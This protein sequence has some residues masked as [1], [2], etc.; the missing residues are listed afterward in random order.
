MQWA[1]FLRQYTRLFFTAVLVLMGASEAYATDTYSPPNL[2][3]PTVTIGGA[4]FTNMVVTVGGIVSGP[5]GS[6]GNGSIDS[7]DPLTNQLTI[8]NVMVGANTYHNVTITVGTLVSVA[9]VTGADSY[10][11]PDLL[12]SSV[13]VGGQVYNDV[14]ITVGS[15]LGLAGG[16]PGAV[17]DVYSGGRLTIPA[18]QVGSRVFTNAVITVGSIVSIGGGTQVPSVVGLTQAAATSAITGA[19]LVLGSVTSASSAT[20]PA[21][22]V[23]SESPAAGT[24]VA[25]NSAVSLVVSSGSGGGGGGIGT[26]MGW[27][28]FAATPVANATPTGQT[29]L[30]VLPANPLEATAANIHWV[31]QNNPVQPIGAA[32]VLSGATAGSAFW[33]YAGFYAALDANNIVEIYQLN[34]TN[35]SASPPAPVPV[36]NF[37]AKHVTDLS[38]IC[39]D[40]TTMQ[41]N[42][43][44]AT[45][46]FAIIHI[47]GS[48]ACTGVSDGDSWVVVTATSTTTVNITTTQIDAFY[49]P[50]GLLTGMV[51]NDPATG[52]ILLYADKSFTNPATLFTGA[53]IDNTVHTQQVA[54][55]TG[56]IGNGTV[57]FRELGKSTGSPSV[58]R[59]DYTG[60]S[61]FKAMPSYNPGTDSLSSDGIFGGTVADALNFYFTDENFTTGATTLYQEPIGTAGSTP[62]APIALYSNTG[63]AAFSALGSNGS[64]VV[65]ETITFGNP[66]TSTLGTVPV[67]VAH[68]ASQTPLGPP[69]GFTGSLSETQMLGG[70]GTDFSHSAIFINLSCPAGA[71]PVKTHPDSTGILTPGNGVLQ[72][73]TPNSVFLIDEG[74]LNQ[75]TL[76]QIRGVTDTTSSPPTDAGGK[77][78]AIPDVDNAGSYAGSVFETC[79]A[80]NAGSCGSTGDF[81]VPA[82]GILPVIVGVSS[83]GQ[84]A[85]ILEINN[86]FSGVVANT[87]ARQI[88]LISI[89]N[90]DVEFAF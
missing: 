17:R 36:G 68:T 71:C 41:S 79:L 75:G 51:L 82:N 7:Y 23:I 59:L 63:I 84:A 57:E 1:S 3:I 18:V 15:I 35:A 12:I 11:P 58:Y 64:V 30:F 13:Q 32:F 44:D 19:H 76:L 8:P 4:T 83:A 55:N 20:V 22:D 34:L 9:S 6:S 40:S 65:L 60:A 70:S 67:G 86:V 37:V 78:Y 54:A 42:E 85:G 45:S 27:Y 77:L 26:G 28:A 5:S 81:V 66:S 49:N 38:L 50:S 47:G 90:T 48:S 33:P 10:S 43:L 73:S 52:N 21:G 29:G 39:S 61:S 53:T 25:Q 24:S 74:A 89:S 88:G 87:S 80:F 31:F 16:M 69:G 46:W 2:L 56:F 72:A 14:T 62:V